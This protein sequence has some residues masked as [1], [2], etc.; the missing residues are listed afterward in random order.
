LPFFER[1]QKTGVFLKHIFGAIECYSTKEALYSL[2]EEKFFKINDDLWIVAM[3]GEPVFRTYNHIAFQANAADFPRV[4]HKL[5]KLGLKILPG[6]NRRPEE[7]ESIYFYD[8]DNH[9]FEFHSG[10]IDE[11]LG[12][13]KVLDE[14]RK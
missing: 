7:G 5:E 2:S 11:R 9:L 8:Y 3:E 6:R 14:R 4:R 10:N 12:H 1:C 13:Y